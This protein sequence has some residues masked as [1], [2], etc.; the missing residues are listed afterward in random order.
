[1]SNQK[2]PDISVGDFAM[3]ILKDMAKDPTKSLKP[4][5]KES[6]IQSSNAPDISHIKVSEDFVTLVTE[7][8]KPELKK[9]EAK[10]RPIKESKEDRMTD[11]VEKLSKLLTEARELIE[12]LSPGATTT[13]N[14]GVNMAKPSKKNKKV[15]NILLRLKS[16]SND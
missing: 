14:L 13:G 8:R 2:F 6:T 11:L 12:E 4:A 7:G 3:D 10:K 15:N 1:M 16:K 9:P 5:L